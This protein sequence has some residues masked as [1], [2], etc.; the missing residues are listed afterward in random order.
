[1]T[2]AARAI[3]WPAPP[4]CCRWPSP[5]RH[6]VSA[7]SVDSMNAMST[8]GS[9]FVREAR[10]RAGSPQREL[11]RKGWHDQSAIAV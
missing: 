2:L 10:K 5:R 1:M 3:R 11:R 7:I 4:R 6:S 8:M 9:D